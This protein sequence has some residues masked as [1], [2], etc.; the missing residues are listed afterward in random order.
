MNAK[1]LL[2]LV[3][4]SVTAQA[5]LIPDARAF[6]AC[7][8]RFERVNR[9]ERLRLRAGPVHTARTAEAGSYQYYF[10]ARNNETTYRVECRARRVGRVVEFA[11]EQGRWVFDAPT[12]SNYAAN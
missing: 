11:M 9:S 3:L 12:N 7:D 4:V 5:D 2:P 6:N 8:Q 1:L 10:N